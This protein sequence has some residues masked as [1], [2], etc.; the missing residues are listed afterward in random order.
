[1]IHALVSTVA[2]R[3][4]SLSE[5]IRALTMTVVPPAVT[6]AASTVP[7]IGPNGVVVITNEKSAYEK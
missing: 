6:K 4:M 2:I 3:A 1:M 7:K 5:S